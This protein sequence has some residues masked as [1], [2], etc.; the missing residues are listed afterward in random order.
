MNFTQECDLSKAIKFSCSLDGTLG[1]AEPK[2][3]ECGTFPEP[4]SFPQFP[5][6]LQTYQIPAFIQIPQLQEE[7]AFAVNV[8]VVNQTMY[9]ICY[10][11]G[12]W[13]P[14]TISAVLDVLPSPE[15]KVSNSLFLQST[16]TGT[17]VW[18]SSPQYPPT[19]AVVTGSYFDKTQVGGNVTLRQFQINPSTTSSV[20]FLEIS[21]GT[22]EY[23]VYSYSFGVSDAIGNIFGVLS[24][25]FAVLK[26]LFPRV[27]K[28][29][30]A[31]VFRCCRKED[32]TKEMSQKEG[33]LE[34][35]V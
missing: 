12:V 31:I 15:C 2:E 5:N 34:A 33:S 3:V 17:F 4:S 13:K 30:T 27:Y 19:A 35:Q 9:D 25:S 26:A 18:P 32:P 29:D 10:P 16:F 7:Q 23:I 24:L 20:N 21:S 14:Q 1:A 22:N 28:A 6:I 11:T 8:S